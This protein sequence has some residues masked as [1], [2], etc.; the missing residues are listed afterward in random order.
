MVRAIVGTLLAVGR[1]KI[2]PA[3]FAQIIEAQDRKQ[4]AEN[5]SPDGLH[6]CQVLYPKNSLTLLQS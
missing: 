3:Q 5:I 2:T 4:A 6:L 1:G